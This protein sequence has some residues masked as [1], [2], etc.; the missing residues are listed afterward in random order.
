MTNM[1]SMDGMIS[2]GERPSPSQRARQFLGGLGMDSALNSDQQLEA[3]AA[4]RLIETLETENQRLR[5]RLGPVEIQ[6]NE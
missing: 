1:D 3:V 6:E 5:A 4:A 2:G